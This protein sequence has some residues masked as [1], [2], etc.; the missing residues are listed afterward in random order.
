MKAELQRIEVEPAIPGDDYFAV[1]HALIGQLFLYRFEQ[2]REI[3]IQRFRVAALD[4]DFIMITKYQST[5]SIPFRF[6]DPV[7][8]CRQFA[9]P[10]G[11]HRQNRRVHR[12]VHASILYWR[13]STRRPTLTPLE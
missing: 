6:E 3:T 10:L 1:E 5:E 13:R 11:E 9:D 12:K 7:A 4:K 8:G 2:L